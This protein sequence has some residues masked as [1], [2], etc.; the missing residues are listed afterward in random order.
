M[1]ERKLSELFDEEPDTWGLRGD[2]NLWKAMRDH[3]SSTYLP[4]SWGEVSV[5]VAE[6]FEQLTGNPLNTL[7]DFHL[8]QFASGGMSS[9]YISPQWWRDDALPFLQRALAQT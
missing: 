5:R 2:P 8:D 7:G 1:V 3:F 9:G 4:E 6:A